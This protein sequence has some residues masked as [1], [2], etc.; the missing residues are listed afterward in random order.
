MSLL[1]T[2]KDLRQDIETIFKNLTSEPIKN[3]RIVVLRM[4]DVVLFLAK[5]SLPFRGHRDSGE[6]DFNGLKQ[7][8]FKEA[9][10]YRRSGDKQLLNS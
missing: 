4:I 9:L 10:E 5:C 7:A 2:V 1:V 3:N 6:F 8:V